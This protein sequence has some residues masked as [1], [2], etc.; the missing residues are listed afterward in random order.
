M[1]NTI[2]TSNG[3]LN[4]LLHQFAQLINHNNSLEQPEISAVIHNIFEE[5]VNSQ[6]GT[7]DIHSDYTIRWNDKYLDES[8]NEQELT[9]EL[10]FLSTQIKE[11]VKKKTLRDVTNHLPKYRKI[12]EGDSLINELDVCSICHDNYKVNEFK[13]ELNLCGHIFH[14]KCIDK[15]FLNN[16]NLECPLCR[17]SYENK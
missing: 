7:L 6:V 4:E 9:Y 1:D 10:T 5:V 17:Q 11:M 13:R 16:K 15:W 14:K 3:V 12:K 8:G 2:I